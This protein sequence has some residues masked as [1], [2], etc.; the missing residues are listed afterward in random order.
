MALAAAMG[1]GRFA[2]TPLL[3]LMRHE[4]LLNDSGG[5]WLAAANYLGYLLGALTAASLPGRPRAQ[6]LGSLLAV[7]ALTAATAALPGLSGWIAVRWAAGMASA[8][9]LVAASSWAVSTLA[10]RDRSD[11]AGWVF[12]GVGLGITCAGAL[13]WWHADRGAAVLWTELGGMALAVT[14]LVAL[15]WPKAS[16]PAMRMPISDAP[17]RGT[18]PRGTMSMVLCYGTLGFGYILPATYLPA[19]ARELIPYPNQ[20]G[21]IWPVFGLAAAC[22]TVLAGRALRRWPGRRI[23]AA[24]HALMAVGCALPLFSHSGIAITGAALLVG[25]TFMVATMTGLQEARHWA[26]DRPQPLVARMTAAFALGQIAGPLIA[27]AFSRVPAHWLGLTGV[28]LAQALAAV[29]LLASACWLHRLPS[30]SEHAHDI[31]PTRA[32]R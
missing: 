10:V 11:A 1:I 20:F 22:S 16:Q 32:T 24:S 28:P 15:C 21:L 14:G 5:A 26:P 27:L 23:W 25:G 7:A 18:V 19:L 17:R 3:P 6:V 9:T 30:H 31:Y 12:A 13:V 4:G 8:W 29:L 2:F